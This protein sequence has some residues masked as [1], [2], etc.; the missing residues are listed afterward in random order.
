VQLGNED[1]Y[2]DVTGLHTE[3]ELDE[4]W[5]FRTRLLPINYNL[6]DHILEERWHPENVRAR[7]VAQ[8]LINQYGLVKDARD[9]IRPSYDRHKGLLDE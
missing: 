2:L 7:E 3:A 1:L 8:A 6:G 5:N 4:V 9:P